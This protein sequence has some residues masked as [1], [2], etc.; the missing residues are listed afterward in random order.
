MNQRN[1]T[2]QF[3]KDREVFIGQVTKNVSLPANNITE[4]EKQTPEKN[5]SSQSESFFCRIRRYNSLKSGFAV[6]ERKTKSFYLHL[7]SCVKSH[8]KQSR[9]D[10]SVNRSLNKK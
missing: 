4:G 6:K 8:N 3:E 10:T 7:L 2:K 1:S 9:T 5:V